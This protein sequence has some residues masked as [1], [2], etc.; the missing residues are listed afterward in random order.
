MINVPNSKVVL[1]TEAKKQ[2]RKMV[3]DGPTCWKCNS[4]LRGHNGHTCPHCGADLVPF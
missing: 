2:L 4:S 1:M 3:K